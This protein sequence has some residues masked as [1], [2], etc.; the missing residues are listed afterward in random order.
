MIVFKVNLM[1]RQWGNL[2][3]LA[4]RAANL[5]QEDFASDFGKSRSLIWQWE[6]GRKRLPLQMKRAILDILSGYYKN[7][8][9]I[10]NI[11][12]IVDD[13]TGH[14]S[15]HFQGHRGLF[16]NKKF[17]SVWNQ[18]VGVDFR[19]ASILSYIPNNCLITRIVEEYTLDMLDQNSDIAQILVFDRAALLEDHVVKR[20]ITPIKVGVGTVLLVREKI[21]H[22]SEVS[23]Q[24]NWA[25]AITRDGTEEVLF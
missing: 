3:R 20:E 15:V 6:S 14:A 2:M 12:S 4:R 16:G 8:P 19:N 11:A 24:K 9:E 10:K 5:T 25:T 17:I 13:C 22:V 7:R 23:S 18:N 1:D 21:F